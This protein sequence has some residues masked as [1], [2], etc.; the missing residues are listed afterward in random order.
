MNTKINNNLNITE[1][2]FGYPSLQY[3]SPS[4]V[5]E[6]D[7]YKM[8]T[9]IIND[10]IPTVGLKPTLTKLKRYSKAGYYVYESNKKIAG[11]LS[12]NRKY[13]IEKYKYPSHIYY[14][15]WLSG[16]VPMHYAWIVSVVEIDDVTGEVYT[17]K[18]RNLIACK[19]KLQSPYFSNIKQKLEKINNGEM[20]DPFTDSYKK[21]WDVYSGLLQ[22]EGGK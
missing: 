16:I 14:Y 7:E 17:V 5:S 13:L 21:I 20:V 6:K 11:N 12:R 10:Y 19:A 4:V 22:I 9:Q 18:G 15:P 2:S 1:G 3:S 8:Q